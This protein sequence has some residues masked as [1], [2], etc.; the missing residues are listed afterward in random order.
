MNGAEAPT[1][2]EVLGVSRSRSGD[3]DE[4][5]FELRVPANFLYFRGHFEGHPVMPAVAQ[6]QCMV[7]RFAREAWPELASLRRLVRVK[8]RRVIRPGD[9]ARVRLTRRRG[10]E[11]VDFDITAGDVPTTS[12]RLVFD[13]AETE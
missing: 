10:G 7:L 9:H 5:V 3:A 11:S 8:F 12:G 4:A 13:L 2:V 6:L 1:E